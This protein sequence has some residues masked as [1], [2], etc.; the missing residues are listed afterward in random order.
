[1]TSRLNHQERLSGNNF[2]G[3]AVIDGISQLAPK[4]HKTGHLFT[5]KGDEVAVTREVRQSCSHAKRK[6]L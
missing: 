3:Q 2:L 1:M 6:Y 4:L 5:G